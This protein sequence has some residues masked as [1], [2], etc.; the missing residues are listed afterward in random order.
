[1][2]HLGTATLKTG[3]LILRPFTLEDAPAMYRNWASDDEVTKYLTWP[4]HSSVDVSRAV[5]AD[6]TAHYADADFYNWAIAL[7]EIGEP[8]GSIGVV[9]WDERVASAHIG[10]CIGRR[11]WRQGITS[12]SLE[13]VIRFL[14]EQVGVNRVDSRHDPKNPNSGRVMA[15]CG[16]QNEGTQ[17][18]ADLNNQGICDFT[19]YGI[20]SQ[21]YFRR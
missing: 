13:A 7:K 9:R 3:R 21:E 15:H 1:M 19:T 2:K 20:L 16:M 12:E 5:L 10:Y 14:F 11:W 17:R 4:T 6:W 8:I 18:Q